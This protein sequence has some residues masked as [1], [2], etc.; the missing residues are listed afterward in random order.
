MVD[1]E[2]RRPTH[3]ARGVTLGSLLVGLVML[4]CS[5]ARGADGTSQAG[6][7]GG[8]TSEVVATVRPAAQATTSPKPI[9]LVKRYPAVG[10]VA[11]VRDET[12]IV[13]HFRGA[14][15]APSTASTM[16]SVTSMVV[17]L[18]CL[19][20]AVHACTKV[21]ARV[22]AHDVQ[23]DTGSGPRPTPSPLRGKTFVLTLAQRAW[24]VS[25]LATGQPASQEELNGLGNS[26]GFGLG[27][28]ADA[29]PDTLEIGQPL[30]GLARL[31]DEELKNGGMS[32]NSA[33][34][35]VKEARQV[36]GEE[37]VVASVRATFASPA[38]DARSVASLSGELLLLVDGAVPVEMQLSGPLTIVSPAVNATGN[39]SLRRVVTYARTT[40]ASGH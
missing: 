23:N 1:I 18:E 15:G 29:L 39:A 20:V 21:K 16:T 17:E 19:E 35:R 37:V 27:E 8:G 30:D 3:A 40:A 10:D 25:D 9:K 28:F 2:T 38:A 4:G 31:I 14:S 22:T 36:N 13:L 6:G 24:T 26:A 32:S 7:P 33:D 11:T 5:G 12:R 34:V